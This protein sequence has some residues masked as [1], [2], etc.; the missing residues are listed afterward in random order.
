MNIIDAIAA[1]IVGFYFVTGYVSGLLKKVLGIMSFVISAVAAYIYYNKGAGLLNVIAL[2]LL[3]NLVLIIVV[4]LWMRLKRK[5]GAILSFS[6]RAAGGIVGSIE[7]AAYVLVMLTTINYFNG[8][9][10]V[11][12]PVIAANLESSFLYSR[13]RKISM[14]P[15]AQIGKEKQETIVFD[16]QT[17]D[18]LRENPS[19]KAM[20]DDKQLLESINQKDYGRVIS[21]PAFLKVINDRELLKELIKVMPKD[22]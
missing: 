3:T 22:H 2:F 11:T 14:G 1:G 5:D 10:S 20:L 18:K 19:L 9:I 13:Y 21:C 17:V 15:N 7:G 4:G 8:I 16:P 12:N 6:S